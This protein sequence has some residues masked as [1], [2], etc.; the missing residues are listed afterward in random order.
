MQAGTMSKRNTK[1]ETKSID[2]EEV[3]SMVLMKVTKTGEA[4]L[5]KT[6]E[7]VI[8]MPVYF[9]ALQQ[10]ATKD[11]GTV[12]GLSVLRIINEPTTANAYGLDRKVGV[13][14]NVLIFYL[15]GDTSEMMH[16][17]SLLRFNLQLE[18]PMGRED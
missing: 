8:T 16:R 15:G 2:T 14:R 17:S 13:E 6:V 7:A 4:Y 11:A 3:C 5:Q 10:K 18:T 1:G 9:N 12:A